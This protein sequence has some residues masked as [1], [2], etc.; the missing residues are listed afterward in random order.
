MTFAH[1]DVLNFKDKRQKQRR[2]RSIAYGRIQ[3]T[4][5]LLQYKHVSTCTMIKA[6]DPRDIFTIPNYIHNYS[7]LKAVINC[8][9]FL[10]F[11]FLRLA[12][13]FSVFCTFA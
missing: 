10:K 4:Y 12:G 6:E 1:S 5:K 8:K 3:G 2:P 7:V 11:T 9:L 13:S